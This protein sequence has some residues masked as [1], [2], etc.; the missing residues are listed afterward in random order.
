MANYDNV[1]HAVQKLK[2]INWLYKA[3]DEC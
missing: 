1:K 3:V 2:E